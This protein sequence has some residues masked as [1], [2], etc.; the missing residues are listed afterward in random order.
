MIGQTDT[1]VFDLL[2]GFLSV[3]NSDFHEDQ[4]VSQSEE[5]NE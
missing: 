3:T 4:A 2:I 5:F 1:Q